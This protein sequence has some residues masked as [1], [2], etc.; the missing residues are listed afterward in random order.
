MISQ[1]MDFNGLPN[2]RDLGGMTG[3]EGRTILPGKLIRSGNLIGADAADRERL[4]SLLSAVVD[5]RT[6]Q[7]RVEK[8]D[9]EFPGVRNHHIPILDARTDGVTREKEAD[10]AIWRERL[11]YPKVALAHVAEVYEGFAASD[12]CISQYRHFVDVLLEEH[13]GA[14]LWH[15]TAGKDRAGFGSVIVQELLGVNREDIFADYLQTNVNMMPQVERMSANIKIQWGEGPE[16][17]EADEAM[18]CIFLARREYLAS[19]YAKIEALY[20]GFEGYITDALKVTPAERE[21]LRKTY[22][23]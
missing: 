12:F 18:R 5:F 11:R 3:F 8:P 2:T 4:G 14:V 6:D 10:E 21:H 23:S 20:G 22:L 15:C 13:K 19:S 1:K 7:E 9:P 17:A 16:A